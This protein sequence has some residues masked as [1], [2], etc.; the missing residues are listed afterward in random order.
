MR[1][2]NCNET[3]HEP[4]AKFCH[5]CGWEFG[6][7][8]GKPKNKTP[9]FTFAESF[10]EGMAMVGIGEHAGFIDKTGTVVI[11]P[12][13]NPSS[14]YSFGYD[15][16][17]GFS[18]GLAAVS[19]NKY[20]I[21]MY[22]CI[23]RHG[24]FVI[25]PQYDVVWP[26][27]EG[28][29]PVL[30]SDQWGFIDKD[31]RV[32]VDPQYRGVK[33][34]SEGLAAVEL[35]YQ[36]YVYIDKTGRIAIQNANRRF[37]KSN[38]EWAN[39]F[40]DGLAAVECDGIKGYINKSGRFFKTKFDFNGDFSEGL[41]VVGVGYNLEGYIDTNM[42]TVIKPQF[43]EA[44]DFHEGMAAVRKGSD[45]GY[46]NTSGNLVIPFQFNKAAPFS[47]GLA[48]VEQ[49]GKL[50]YVDKQGNMVISPRFREARG[51]SEGMAAVE[52]NNRWG[53]I[54]KTGNYAF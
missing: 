27:S 14:S 37:C 10:S 40:H 31:G 50:G 3:E 29:A 43:D 4:T 21:V 39:D 48:A 53:F 18:E 47:E 17:N 12:R 6:K 41:A 7:V 45:W 51:F 16:R 20:P 52:E 32:V 35:E 36:H 49:N 15:I 42:N 8:F 24:I 9:N 2:P 38:L 28:L 5:N 23:D 1:C 54:D 26:F 33:G 44:K 13:Y 25:L 19:I 22:G 34:F 46:I 11:E 30:L